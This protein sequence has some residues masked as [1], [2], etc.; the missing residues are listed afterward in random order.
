[1]ITV[2]SYLDDRSIVQVYRTGNIRLRNCILDNCDMFN[3]TPNIITYIEEEI[4]QEEYDRYFD[5]EYDDDFLPYDE[6][7]D[8]E[9]DY[10]HDYHIPTHKD[11]QH[12]YRS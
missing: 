4:E 2:M 8:D 9:Y 3:L 11:I 10:D 6:E 12:V 5:D 7:I 1:V